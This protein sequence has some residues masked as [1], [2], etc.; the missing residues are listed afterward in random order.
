MID[1]ATQNCQQFTAQN[2]LLA[3]TMF[4]WTRISCQHFI[5]FYYFILFLHLI[6]VLFYYIIFKLHFILFF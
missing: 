2:T 1:S 5:L 3:Q 4:I 6:K